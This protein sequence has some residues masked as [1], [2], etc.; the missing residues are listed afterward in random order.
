MFGR[1]K[2]Q[3]LP[4]PAEMTKEMNSETT[5]LDN[6]KAKMDLILTQMDSLR[7]EYAVLNERTKTMEKLLNE[8]I[9]LA[10]S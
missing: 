5:T 10:K 2:Q 7:T 9:A 1:K 8:I 4:E 6:V 3:P